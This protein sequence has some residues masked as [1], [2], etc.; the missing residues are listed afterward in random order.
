MRKRVFREV[1]IALT[2]LVASILFGIGSD[3]LKGTDN[4]CSPRDNP[5]AT[6]GAKLMER[7]RPRTLRATFVTA[8]LLAS[9]KL[10]YSSLTGGG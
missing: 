5:E 3:V 10:L 9:I 4:D 2:F 6:L 7:L 1:L 8:L